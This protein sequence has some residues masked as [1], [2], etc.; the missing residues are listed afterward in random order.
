MMMF[1]PPPFSGK[2]KA[3]A[4][5]ISRSRVIHPA[6]AFGLPLNERQLAL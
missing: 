5:G 1:A 3:S 6:D 4:G 2:P